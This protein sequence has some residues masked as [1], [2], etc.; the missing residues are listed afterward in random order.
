MSIEK[1]EKSFFCKFCRF[2]GEGIGE[3]DQLD[4]EIFLYKGVGVW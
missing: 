4:R 1:K 3:N 2:L